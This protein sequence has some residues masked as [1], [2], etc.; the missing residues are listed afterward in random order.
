MQR[1]AAVKYL[2]VVA[3]G[4]AILPSCLHRKE[5]ASIALKHLDIDANQE[6]LLSEIAE[7]I[8]PAGSAPGARDTYAHLFV[9]RM[10]DDCYEA[11]KQQTFLRGLKETDDLARKKF[12]TSFLQSSKQQRNEIVSLLEN[13]NTSKNAVDFYL[14][15]KNLTIQG[16]LTSKPVLGNIFRYELVPGRYNGFFPVNAITH[17]A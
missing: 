16:Y 2:F 5:T 10:V 6:K 8:I 15:M 11:E 3:A 14:M 17:P 13:E 1:R 9:L 4:S 7:T 12:G